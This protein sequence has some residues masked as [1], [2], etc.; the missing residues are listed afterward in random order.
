LKSVGNNSAE[1]IISNKY[2]VDISIAA[3]MSP[4]KVEKDGIG[5]GIDY[6]NYLERFGI[7][8][9][10]DRVRELLK[11]FG[12]PHRQF[13]TVLVGGTNGKGSVTTILSSLLSGSGCRCGS[14]LSPHILSLNERISIDGKQISMED[15]DR[16]MLDIRD[17]SRYHNIPITQFE[18]LTALAYIYFFRNRVNIA[19]ME[20]GMGGRF[21]ATNV[22]DPALSIITNVT[23]DHTEHLGNT[24]EAIADEKLGIIR[25]DSVTLLGPSPE[26]VG[27]GYIEEKTR[28]L[29]SIRIVN[30]RD[31]SVKIMEDR[32]GYTSFDLEVQPGGNHPF[33][34][35]SI[36]GLRVQGAR[37]QAL[38]ASVAA[39]AYQVLGHRDGFRVSDEHLRE[40]LKG[41][42][43]T[44]RFQS[45]TKTPHVIL[46]CA[47]NPSGMAE[48]S[49]ALRSLIR[50]KRETDS[51][52]GLNYHRKINWVCSFMEDKDIAGMMRE[53]FGVANNVFLSQLPLERSATVKDLT[54]KTA[55]TLAEGGKQNGRLSRGNK[56]IRNYS[57]FSHP[58]NAIRAALINTTGYDILVIAGSIYSLS[59]YIDLLKEYNILE[60]SSLTGSA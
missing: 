59:T 11:I 35:R 18:A 12:D 60:K 43:L 15:L 16:G 19:V 45:I 41:F 32:G 2:N 21:D 5:E 44:G 29:S 27:Y 23:L 46:D 28:E 36:Y 33:T 37:Y 39:I 48:L 53:I 3:S 49:G 38:N 20:V 25:K 47:H 30:G 17:K 31:F 4:I 57:V 42:S 8:L 26:Q 7:D 51:A 24:V 10:L 40:T 54:M 34:L 55:E 1:Y 9:S 6:Y 14:Y 13:T 52:K 58:E 22:A 56:K 50:E